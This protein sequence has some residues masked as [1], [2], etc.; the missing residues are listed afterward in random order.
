MATA[1]TVPNFSQ[2]NFV[3][4]DRA[5]VI[6]K[7]NGVNAALEQ[8][9]NSLTAMTDSIN[10][11]LQTM[12]S[13][14]TDTQQAAQAASSDAEQIA[15]DKQAVA[16][17]R[18]HVDQQKS[19]IDTTAGE[20][21]ANA[22]QVATDRQAVAEDTQTATDAAAA[23]SSA[24][25]ASIQAK[26]DAEAL[27]G[28]LQAVE[29][30]KTASQ[31]AATTAGEERTLAEQA[32]GG[33]ETAQSA[34]E[35]AA[36]ESQGAADAAVSNH[37]TEEDPHT[38][39]EQKDNLKALAYVDALSGADIGD[40]QA[41]QTALQII[42][43]AGRGVIGDGPDL[44]LKG[45]YGVGAADNYSPNGVNIDNGDSSNGFWRADNSRQVSA[46]WP[47]TPFVGSMI[48][49]RANSL[50][51]SQLLLRGNRMWYRSTSAGAEIG[52]AEVRSTANTT[53]DSNGF[54]KSAS[55]IFRLS[56]DSVTAVSEEQKFK[57]AGAGAANG[58]AQGVTA[59]HDAVGVYTVIGSLGFA[60]N[61]WTVEVPQ[62][63]NGNRLCVVETEQAD[64]GTITVRTFSKTVDAATGD[65][66]ADAPMDIPAGRWV[67]LRLSMPPPPTNDHP[68][69][70]EETP[71]LTPEQQEQARIEQLDR[72]R[73]ATAVSRLQALQSLDDFGYLDQVET[74]ITNMPD[75]PE[76]RKTKR[77]WA[78]AQE[79]RRMSP[80]IIELLGI[81]ELTPEQA[82]ELFRHALTLEF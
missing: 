2:F 45:A 37:V 36:S 21:D 4:N 47:L 59:S 28:D 81:L 76:G 22:Q 51:V 44:L 1:P 40:L 19:A 65:V 54:I 64:D 82:D 70:V 15:L 75:T 48:Q 66:I 69:D 32:R 62:D 18:T 8:F 57:E 27:Y 50:S 33:A 74:I 3:V 77:A 78:E 72:W 35:I 14:K 24:A 68:D 56:N 55:P 31:Q 39:Y 29:D 10:E 60:V 25:N 9:G 46:Y 7:Q 20:V 52:F 17:D 38:Q 73:A 26:D 63:S 58:E 42:N 53:I 80:T 43:V 79:F 12:E 11:D 49:T 67:D 34:A 16:D 13:Q 6:T 61:G 30:A 41:L 71:A 23:S 5:A